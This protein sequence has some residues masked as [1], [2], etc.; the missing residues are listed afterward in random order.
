MKRIFISIILLTFLGCAE[1]QT[2]AQS[3]KMIEADKALESSKKCLDTS[4][5]IQHK[6]DLVTKSIVKSVINKVNNYRLKSLV[7][8]RDTVFIETKKNFWGRTKT[9]V[10]ISSDSSIQID[11]IKN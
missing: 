9:N 2:T 1:R 5:V 3:Q 11:S 7:V 10:R 8:K 6:A 4:L